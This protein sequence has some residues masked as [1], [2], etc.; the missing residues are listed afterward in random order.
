MGS[1][2]G[3]GGGDINGSNKE[4]YFWRQILAIIKEVL[5]NVSQSSYDNIDET[6]IKNPI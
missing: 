1:G 2:R 6:K 4:K 5:I 3:G